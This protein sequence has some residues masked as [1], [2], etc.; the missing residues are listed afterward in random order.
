[1]KKNSA[2]IFLRETKD[3]GAH[4][5]IDH[6]R[7]FMKLSFF[8]LLLVLTSF[9]LLL[10]NEGRGQS[11]NN[12]KVNIELKNESLLPALKKI[13]SKVN[14]R[15]AFKD[16]DL[17]NEKDVN[18][19]SGTKSLQEI[20][21]Q[22]LGGRNL[23]FKQIGTSI[24]I[25]KPEIVNPVSRPEDDK[26]DEKPIPTKNLVSGKVIDSK[27]D[28]LIGVTI[29]EKGT[30]N[31]TVTDKDGKFSITVENESSVLLLRYIGYIDTEVKPGTERSITVTL[32]ES[33][34]SLN[35]VVVIGYGTQKKANTTAAISTLKGQDIAQKPVASL[36]NSLTGRVAG[37]IITQGNGEPGQ[38]AASI[39]IRGIGTTGNNS[40][41]I[42]V[43]GVYRS[44]ESLDPNT[45]ESFTVLKDAAAVAPYG[46]AGANGVILIT[47][48][49]GK[50]GKP[51]LSYN[52]Y[53]GFQN[54][55]RMT[56]MVN[57]Y[58][59]ALMQNEAAQND[60]SAT[61]PYSQADLAGY[62]KT[63]NKSADADIDKYPSSNGLKDLIIKNRIITS[64]NI[65]LSGG[66]DKVH[67]YAGLG[68]IYQQGQWS[69][70]AMNRYN[71]IA[72][73][74]AQATNTTNVS[75]SINSYVKDLN[76]PGTSAGNIMYQAFR[77]PP[78]FAIKYSNGLYGGY[79]NRSL[80]G[81]VYDTGYDKEEATQSYTTLTIDQKLPLKGLSLK[82][83]VSYD[84]YS[85]YEKNWQ[86]PATYYSV[87]TTTTPYTFSKA[88][89][90]QS[91]PLLIIQN[92]FSSSLTYQSYLNYHNTFGKSDITL[93]GVAEYRAV[94][95]RTQRDERDNYNLDIDELDAGSA[96]STDVKNSGSS[97]QQRQIGYVYHATYNY[98]GKY[99][100]EA[101][102][103]YDGHYYFAPGHRYGFFPTFG[104]SWN[105]SEESFIK[106]RYNWI[107]FLK[108][109]ASYGQSGNLAGGPFQYLS[110]Y[111]LGSGAVFTSS[112]TPKAT[113]GV[114]ESGQPNPN[115]TWERQKQ[116]DVGI[117]GSLWQ[118]KLTFDIDYFHQERNN[119]LV[120]RQITAP[121]EYGIS[122][123]QENYGI[124]S[125]QGIDLTLGTSQTLSNGM[126]LGV[127]AILSYARNKLLRVDELATSY[128]NLNT[129]QT[130]RSLGTPFGYVALGYFTTNDFNANGSLKAGIPTQPWGAVHPGDIRYADLNNDGKIS[131]D[132]SD[133]KVIGN[134]STPGIQFSLAPNFSWK[135]FDVDLLFQGATQSSIQIGGTIA[136]P[137]DIASSATTL[138][139]NDH[140]T[141]ANT[142]ALY[143]RLTPA[144]VPNNQQYSSWFM[145][146][147]TYV[148]LK[149][150]E[151]GYTIPVKILQKIKIQSIRF[152]VAGQ[153][154]WTWTPYIKEVI[155]PEAQS[156]NGQ[157]YFQQQVISFGTNI[158]F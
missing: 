52:S 30:T 151:I 92:D 105:L 107:D 78:T 3:N 24:I 141:P 101:I 71:L 110:A 79:Q 120:T 8:V 133:Q 89:D 45:V 33:E 143:P 13:E 29:I 6:V 91:N 128:N 119:M 55:T 28:P 11:I 39:H 87:N 111:Q 61:T 2:F 157:Y 100:A 77:N 18:V 112:G 114:F 98:D 60:N 150:A 56:S 38:D 93:Q 47:T 81:E 152:Y 130:G 144:P 63:V 22:I 137:F 57:S 94:N 158:T 148:R 95:S 90:G 129:R 21:L 121:S 132:N 68:Y 19:A 83:S 74:D 103:R 31:G 69:S 51:T 1:M 96:N 66:T 145:R 116:L 147:N 76:Y 140:W 10:A 117:E 25:Y 82:G 12:V 5:F 44:F 36:S 58:Q 85:N 35:E 122:L 124:M 48:K 67:Y 136:Y 115:I 156:T 118:G 26:Q 17:R 42:V 23:D 32:K 40:P 54:P 153:N 125:N 49:K 99:V 62:L 102:G 64:H 41:L 113:Q 134:P 9:Q 43:D 88:Q 126:R 84:P 16:Q 149:S 146:N 14:F 135:G 75:V 15:F 80:L 4:P 73:I 131:T 72:K 123:S 70:T 139:F 109:R 106:N 7:Y 142:N 138:Q 108:L 20:L 65:Q 86:K 46:L 104:L 155:D 59:Y 127:K 37:V 50:S 27:G 97:S 53:V 34:R 154:L